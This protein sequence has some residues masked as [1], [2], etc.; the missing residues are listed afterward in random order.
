MVALSRADEMT[1]VPFF[2]KLFFVSLNL[3]IESWFCFSSVLTNQ[4][5]GSKKAGVYTILRFALTILRTNATSTH[6]E[7]RKFG[8]VFRYSDFSV[9]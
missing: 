6:L 7:R 9:F 1:C 4:N 5:V 3:L 8:H 2:E